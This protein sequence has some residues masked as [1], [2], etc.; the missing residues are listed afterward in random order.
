MSERILEILQNTLN[1]E[2][3]LINISLKGYL[4]F[5][6]FSFAF[7]FYGQSLYFTRRFAVFICP[8]SSA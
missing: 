2:E 1:R 4:D 5:D 3:H 7:I 8:D 6:A